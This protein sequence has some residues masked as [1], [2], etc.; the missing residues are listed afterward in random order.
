MAKILLYTF[1]VSSSITIKIVREVTFPVSKY[2]LGSLKDLERLIRDEHFDYILG[3]GNYNGK[4]RYIRIECVY[5]NKYRY[6]NRQIINSGKS[7]YLSTWK[8]SKYK[9]SAIAKNVLYGPCNRSAYKM[10]ALIDE[11]NLLTKFAFIHIPKKCDFD[12]ALELVNRWLKS[13]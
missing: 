11:N 3:L 5:K 10:S 7:E 2:Y 4:S 8:L 13:V 12:T 1:N 6:S 9:G